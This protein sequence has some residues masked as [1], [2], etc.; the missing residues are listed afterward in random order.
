MGLHKARRAAYPQGA[1]IEPMGVDHRGADVLAPLQP[2]G[3]N[4][5]AEG[6]AAGG[7]ADPSCSYRLYDGSLYQCGIDGMAPLQATAGIPPA[8]L[9]GN[10]HGQPQSRLA[11]GYFLD[12]AYGIST[13]PQ[14]AA[15]SVRCCCRTT[16]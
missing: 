3:G 9:L 2:M 6:M 14:L 15:R 7:F 13:C 4:E 16:S 5:M 8:I 1:A 12:R 10:T 11:W